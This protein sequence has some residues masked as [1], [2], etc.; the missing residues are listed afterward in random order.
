MFCF[1]FYIKFEQRESNHNNFKLPLAK[2]SEYGML[3]ALSFHAE[4]LK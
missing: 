2:N 4:A 1:G 3:T